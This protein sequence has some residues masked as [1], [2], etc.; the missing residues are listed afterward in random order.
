MK[1]VTEKG[2][3]TLL[4]LRLPPV[5]NNTLGCG[6]VKVASEK[7]NQA[8][9]FVHWVKRWNGKFKGMISAQNLIFNHTDLS[10]LIAT[11]T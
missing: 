1:G 9:C 8:P 4:P 5:Q 11:C 2:C 6:L 10:D 7:K 3:L